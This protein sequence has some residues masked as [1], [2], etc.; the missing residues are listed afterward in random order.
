MDQL[1]NMM[2]HVNWHHSEKL[3]SFP[4]EQQKLS[5]AILTSRF[6]AQLRE[7]SATAME[8]TRCVHVFMEKHIRLFSANEGFRLRPI[9]PE[10]QPDC[11]VCLRQQGT[12]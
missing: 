9:E 3:R 2:Q 8:L 10:L 6:A 12:Q 5:K 1:A 4:R 11:H 7:T